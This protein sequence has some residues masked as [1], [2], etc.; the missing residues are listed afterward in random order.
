MFNTAITIL[1]KRHG[2]ILGIKLWL[3][4]SFSS[5]YCNIIRVQQL[6]GVVV[7]T[8]ENL[9]GLIINNKIW[10]TYLNGLFIFPGSSL[11]NV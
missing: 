4:V 2:K 3:E 10:N 11:W 8:L 9:V 1:K 7:P 5:F 6:L